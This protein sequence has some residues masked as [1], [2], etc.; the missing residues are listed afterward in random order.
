MKKLILSLLLTAGLIAGFSSDSTFD[1]SGVV[2]RVSHYS[3]YPYAL[4]P[5]YF[6]PDQNWHHWHHGWGGWGWHHRHHWRYWHY[7]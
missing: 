1:Q 5:N 6:H 4:Y 2:V 3:P 7:W